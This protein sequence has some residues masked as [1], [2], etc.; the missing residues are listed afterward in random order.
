MTVE[1]R[2]WYVRMLTKVQ[3][4][5]T[6]AFGTVAFYLSVAVGVTVLREQ[7]VADV[8]TPFVGI[9]LVMVAAIL[10]VGVVLP[11]I[12]LVALKRRNEQ[13]ATAAFV[14][15]IVQIVL[16]GGLL[17]VF[18][19]ISLVLLLNKDASAYIGMK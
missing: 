9:L 17:S 2:I 19:I 12:V 16:G 6:V 8:W 14:S 7:G 18:P 11:W 15:L 3:I 5:L 1:K 4:G 10:A 13:W